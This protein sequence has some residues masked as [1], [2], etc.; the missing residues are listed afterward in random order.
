MVVVYTTHMWVF[1]ADEFHFCEICNWNHV[2][3]CTFLKHA[4]DV[5]LRWKLQGNKITKETNN[6]INHFTAWTSDSFNLI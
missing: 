5:S 3:L 4:H 1:I 2:H 6:E